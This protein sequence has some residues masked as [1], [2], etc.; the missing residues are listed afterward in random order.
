MGW[1]QLVSN[2]VSSLI[3]PVV[4]FVLASFVFRKR[5]G[6]LLNRVAGLIDRIKK[7]T[8]GPAAFELAEV[9]R[10]A[11]VV[12][13]PP[14]DPKATAQEFVRS[15]HGGGTKRFA[16][17]EDVVETFV[18]EK[19]QDDEG[20]RRAEVERLVNLSMRAGWTL[21]KSGADLPV[22]SFDEQGFGFGADD[23]AG[24]PAYTPPPRQDPE[25]FNRRLQGHFEPSSD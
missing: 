11:Q 3:W 7:L 4:V 22:A 2:L 8:V 10:Q 13:G 20:P 21:G 23:S 9:S 16:S 17:H 5:V 18:R 25:A 15:A 6:D 19:L 12:L 1:Q 14:M 24:R